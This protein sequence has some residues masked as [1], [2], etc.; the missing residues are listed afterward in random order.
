VRPGN[1][2]VE[3]TD[4]LRLAEHY[5]DSR[6][7]D[8]QGR[9][10]LRRWRGQWHR[11]EEGGYA[12]VEDE[13]VVG[14]IYRLLDIS[15]VRKTKKKGDDLVEVI[16]PVTVNARIV[17]E[18]AKALPSRGI[19]ILGDAPQWLTDDPSLPDPRELVVF[20]NG[21]LDAATFCE[22]G[23]AELIPPTPDYFAIGSCPYNFDPD[24]KCPAFKRWIAETLRDEETI[25]LAQEWA[26]LQ[27][28]PDNRHEKFAMLVGPPR[29]G[30]GTFVT[31]LQTMLGPGQCATTS[32]AKL[33]GRFGLSPLLGKLS[34]FMPDAHIT[35]NTDARGALE[36]LKSITGSDCQ[37]ID[38][39]HRDEL[40]EV[41]MPVR[42]TVAVNELP[43][44]PDDAG[45][46][47]ERLLM[48]HFDRSFA[49]VE[50]TTLK[51]RIR[52]EGPGIAVWALEGLRRLRR[53]GRFTSPSKSV[54]MIK[55]FDNAVNPVRGFLDEKCELGPDFWDSKE[56][57]FQAWK[58]WAE[59]RGQG[60]GTKAQFGQR[61]I[62]T[63][64]V[65]AGKAGPMGSQ[66]PVYRG[67]RLCHE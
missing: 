5:I 16:E 63:G 64:H 44:L 59:D 66:F 29:S 65:R 10:M 18:V 48:L 40:P 49:G 41:H 39:K 3:S 8:D 58:A 52:H 2:I 27:L 46:L 42:F 7:R 45:A 56:N 23:R 6:H 37:A 35:R 47:K 26:G 61:L 31:A 9:A 21:I 13:A 25:A 1:H 60:V 57:V 19:L 22:T 67:L 51:A 54:A 38:R 33:S 30:K 17:N 55:E 36:V 20:R 34:A 4:P 28:V 50:D 24:A 62:N 12:L 32:F 43:E 15:R 11:Y 14:D 53:Q